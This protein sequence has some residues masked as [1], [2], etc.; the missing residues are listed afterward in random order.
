MQFLQKD[1]LINENKPFSFKKENEILTLMDDNRAAGTWLYPPSY[2][3]N[4]DLPIRPYRPN[5]LE[6]I[7]IGTRKRLKE[8]RQKYG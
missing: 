4:S 8:A 2:L 3:K 5:D 1:K 6:W 7:D